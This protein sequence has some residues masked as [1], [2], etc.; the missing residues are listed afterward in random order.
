MISR[1]GGLVVG[2]L[3][4]V[5]TLA[6]M[7]AFLLFLQR[8]LPADWLL[9][10][11]LSPATAVS[12]NVM[13]VLLWGLQHTGMASARYKAWSR[14][15]CAE[16]LERSIYCLFTAAALMLI[17]LAWVPVPGSIYRI[18]SEGLT[19][20]I[21]AAFW[22]AWGVFFVSLILDSYTEFFGL[23][24]VYCYAM[25]RPFTMSSFKTRNFHRFVRHPSLGLIILGLWITP[26][27]TVDRAML[28]GLL[29][30]YTVFGAVSA[31]RKFAGYYGEPYRRRQ[32]QVPLLVP[33]LWPR[34]PASR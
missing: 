34:R 6:S 15:F 10:P 20:A 24:Q 13:I 2:V 8:A 16:A 22:L 4:H 33:R 3:C 30:V 17:V 1:F 18:Q 27:L 31:D 14:R 5:V 9:A 7:L 11:V 28:A 21:N 12:V 23:R 32:R 26:H 19:T 25:R 29:T